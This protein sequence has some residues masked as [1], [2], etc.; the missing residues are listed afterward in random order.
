M[1]SPTQITM[2]HPPDDISHSIL[3]QV[4]SRYVPE[5]S[6]PSQAYFFFSYTVQITNEGKTPVQLINRYWCITDGLGRVNEVQGPGVV[7]KQP[8]LAPGES[9][10]YSSFCPLPT[11]TG[12]MSGHYE[13]QLQ[14]GERFQAKIPTFFLV[15]PSS[16]N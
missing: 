6:N 2:P 16:F 7:G 9:F 3:V 1:A 8:H 10:E 12:T 15:E 11:P 5:E 13:M 14:T 4:Q